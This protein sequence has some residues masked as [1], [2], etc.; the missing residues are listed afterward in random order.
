VSELDRYLLTSETC[1]ATVRRHWAVLLPQGGAVAVAW[2][3]W[4]WVLSSFTSSYLSS[5]ATFFFIFSFLW[6]AWMVV[7]WSI[8]M[9]AVTDKRV[10]LVSGLLYKRV[11]VMPLSKVTDMTYERSPLGRI[12]GY[13]T[14]LMESAGQDQALSRIDFVRSPDRLYFQLSEELFGRERKGGG[15][16]GPDASAG[17]DAST[18][19]P[20]QSPD[21]VP[22]TSTARLPRLP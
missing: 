21:A 10:L 16:R 18:D 15:R 3:A 13:G 4:L 20:P 5:V 11:A 22:T 17:A 8:E 1:V 2:I 12:L 6:I 19:L 9:F 14:F 7:E